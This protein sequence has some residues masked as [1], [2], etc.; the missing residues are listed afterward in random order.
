MA[1]VG[2]LSQQ[3]G[4]LPTPTR[5]H[6]GIVG[7]CEHIH[8]VR[9][10]VGWQRNC[11]FRTQTEEAMLQSCRTLDGFAR[12]S[13]AHDGLDITTLYPGVTLV[14]R[15]RHSSYRLVVLEAARRLVLAQGGVFNEPTVV[16]LS[17][18]TFGGSTLKLGWILVGL[19]VEFGLG[20]R[21]ITTSPVQSVTIENPSATEVPGQ[22]AA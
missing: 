2:G 19:R 7:K 18:A 22:R 3:R 17:G 11:P 16:H 14:V 8:A 13:S 21:Q 4:K 5:L 10:L 9:A 6:H 1:Q 15:T 12:D 20:A